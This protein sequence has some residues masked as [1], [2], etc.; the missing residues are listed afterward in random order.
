MK[1]ANM[2]WQK[3]KPDV[4]PLA[5]A[6]ELGGC[7]YRQVL[8]ALIALHN[9]VRLYVTRECRARVMA[10]CQSSRE[11]VGGILVG[12][13]MQYE[14]TSQ[15]PEECIVLLEQAVPSRMGENSAVRVQ[16]DTEIWDRVAPLLHS[17][18]MV[19]GWYHSHPGL[20]VFFSSMDRKTQAAYFSQHYTVGWVIDPIGGQ[21]KVFCGPTAKL[22]G[23]PLTEIEA[24]PSRF[25]GLSCG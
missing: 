23:A 8:H 1:A 20:G 21:E 3:L 14:T 7:G 17:G 11:E 10:H 25:Q 22:Y 16:M 9:G 2:H 4:G 12:R 6:R 24:W 13:A 19:V 18:Q 15:D 5:L